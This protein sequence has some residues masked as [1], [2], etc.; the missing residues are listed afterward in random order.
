MSRMKGWTHIRT[1]ADVTAVFKVYS[2]VLLTGSRSPMTRNATSFCSGV[3]WWGGTTKVAVVGVGC[4]V[5]P[6]THGGLILTT[7]KSNNTN[8]QV[9]NAQVNTPQYANKRVRF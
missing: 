8:P 6:T 4:P 2:F 9:Y 7:D 5:A 1:C 3:S